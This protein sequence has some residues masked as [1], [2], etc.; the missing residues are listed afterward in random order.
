MADIREGYVGRGPLK[1]FVED[2]FS[3]F[4]NKLLLP[5]GAD[6]LKE[7]DVSTTRIKSSKIFANFRV[8]VEFKNFIGE[9]RC[10]LKKT[11]HEERSNIRENIKQMGREKSVDILENETILFISFHKRSSAKVIAP[12]VSTEE[13]KAFLSKDVRKYF[14][15]EDEN[16][17]REK[18]YLVNMKVIKRRGKIDAYYIIDVLGE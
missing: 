7:D 6:E 14:L 18:E 8:Q 12:N 2:Y 11:T 3:N 1:S 9:V 10:M 4:I 5:G 15:N 17:F 16:M 13:V